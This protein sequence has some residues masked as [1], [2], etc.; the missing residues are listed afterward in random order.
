M[1]KK[2]LKIVYFGTPVISANVLKKL[3]DNKY[4]VIALVAQSDKPVG[5]KQ[6]VMPVPTKKVAIEYGI[7]CFQPSKLK[8]DYEFIKDLH[9]D[10][11][12]TFAYGQILPSELLKYPKYISLNLHGSLLPKYRGAS[13][14]Q[15]ALLNGDKETGISLM[16]MVPKM[17]AGEVFYKKAIEIEDDDTYD[18]L[19]EKLSNLAFDVFEEG[20]EDII[21][22][23]NKGEPQDESLVTF[24]N[25]INYE[26][27]LIRFN[28]GALTIHNKIRAYTS[29]PGAHFIYKNEKIK[30]TKSKVLSSKIG[31]PGQIIDFSKDGLKVSTADNVIN[32]LELQRPGKKLISINDFY[33]GNRNFFEIGDYIKNSWLN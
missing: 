5:R 3:L 28:E 10:I 29:S 6:I 32:I 30:I 4:N 31:T 26:D 15:Y 12:L 22:G 7:P 8:Y 13:P 25:K 23:S 17:D 18:T 19:Q 27:S 14:I 1:E 20:I 24:A 11:I 33:N 16:R 9:A 2:D 21:N